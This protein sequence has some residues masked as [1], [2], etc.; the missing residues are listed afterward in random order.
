MPKENSALRTVLIAERDQ[1]VR[2]LQRVFLEKA[3]FRIDFVDDGLAALERTQGDLPNVLVTEILLPK[4][5]GLTLCRQIRAKPELRDLPVI[6]LSILSAA[7]RAEEAGATAI[8]RKPIVE[9]V[10]VAAVVGA[11]VAEPTGIRERP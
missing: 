6:V 9:S 11:T 1:N 4:L 7:T 5:D 8:L 10:F 2:D 3:G